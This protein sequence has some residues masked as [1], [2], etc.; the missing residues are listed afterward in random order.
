MPNKPNDQYTQAESLREAVRSV[1]GDRQYLDG[2]TVLDPFMGS[3]STG[4][5]A[6]NLNRN[7]IGIELDEEYFEIARRYE[8]KSSWWQ[9]HMED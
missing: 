4:V 3:G 8:H 7:F 1:I 6:K 2:D 9:A 5:A